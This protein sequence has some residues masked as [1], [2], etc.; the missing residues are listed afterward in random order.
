MREELMLVP[1]PGDAFLSFKGISSDFIRFEYLF[2][3]Q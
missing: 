1:P 3:R 2:A